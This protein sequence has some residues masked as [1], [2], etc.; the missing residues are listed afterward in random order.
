M[1]MAS[2]TSEPIPVYASGGEPEEILVWLTENATISAPVS[3]S[4]DGDK[5]VLRM[6]KRRKISAGI[7][8]HHG[9]VHQRNRVAQFE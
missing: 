5:Y 1:V 9:A 6:C 2:N 4:P 7:V 8:G 3:H